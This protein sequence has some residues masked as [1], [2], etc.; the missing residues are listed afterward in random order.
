[1]LSLHF[2]SITLRIQNSSVK[3]FSTSNYRISS[4][5]SKMSWAP[6]CWGPCHNDLNGTSLQGPD[7]NAR[8]RLQKRKFVQR[9]KLFS[10]CSI[11][12]SH[13][14]N[15]CLNNNHSKFYLAKN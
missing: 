6:K 5:K 9:T 12:S 15:F 10:H 11:V 13:Q 2:H 7:Y 1:M 14:I 8:L 3:I 4:V